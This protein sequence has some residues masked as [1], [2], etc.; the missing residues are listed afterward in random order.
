MVIIR[1]KS[2][3]ATGM[4]NIHIIMSAVIGVAYIHIFADIY[5]LTHIDVFMY[6]YILVHINSPVEIVIAK[7]AASPIDA[8]GLGSRSGSVKFRLT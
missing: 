4:I 5:I 3:V 7:I 8:F 1:V 6:C 2:P